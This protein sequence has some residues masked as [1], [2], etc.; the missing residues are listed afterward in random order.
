[1]GYLASVTNANHWSSFDDV[2]KAVNRPGFADG[3]GYVFTEWD[4]FCGLDLDNIWLSDADE[5]APW[6]MRILQKFGDTYSEVS[7]SG[8]GVKIWMKAKAPR[9]GKWPIEYGTI[10]VYDCARFFTVT[11]RSAGVTTITDH[12]ADVDALVAN[13]DEDRR[14]QPCAAIPN[15][16]PQGQRHNTLVSLAGTMWRR[17]MCPEA[18]AAALLATNQQ[19]CNPPHSPEH[20]HKIVESMRRWAR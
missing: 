7:P 3:I 9:C 5:G 16:I 18:I 8:A 20:V 13:L 19:Q 1:M 11:G 4:P 15:V 2:I 10:E 17:G 14:Q 12:Q 6:A